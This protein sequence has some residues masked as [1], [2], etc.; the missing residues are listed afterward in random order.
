MTIPP[1][2]AVCVLTDIFPDND[3]NGITEAPPADQTA[4]TEAPPAIQT[5]IT[6]PQTQQENGLA[7]ER[8]VEGA[9]THAV[10]DPNG[11]S[12]GSRHGLRNSHV[13]TDDTAEHEHAPPA[14][15][16]AFAEVRHKPEESDEET[17][18]SDGGF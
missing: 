6:V 18:D 1:F 9:I 15:S 12:S 8:A 2:P 4:I 14:V 17:S 10:P 3:A 5:A 13:D 7:E 16:A 11:S